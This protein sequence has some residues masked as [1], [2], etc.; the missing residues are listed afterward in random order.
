MSQLKISRAELGQFL[1]EYQGLGSKNRFKGK[2]GIL[3]YF[4]RVGC[5]QYDPLNVVGRN[6]DLT[7]QS[8]IDGYQKSMLH[9]LLY[10]ERVLVDGWDKQMSIYKSV[11]WNKMEH[12]RTS[13]TESSIR[14]LKHRK[15]IEALDYTEHVKDKLKELGATKPGA[16]DIGAVVRGTWG[17]GK[18]SSVV[19]DF[20]F[21][22]GELGIYDKAGTQKVYDFIENLLSD[23]VLNRKS[24]FNNDEDFYDWYV[25]RR[26]GSQG[27]YWDK[28]GDGWLGQYISK[29][30]IRKSAVERLAKKGE[31]LP[32]EV[33][34]F[35]E[36]FYIRKEDVDLLSDFLNQVKSKSTHKKVR[37]LAPLDNFMWDRKLIEQVFG[38]NYRW[39]VYKPQA[40]REYGYYVL[41][42]LY[43]DKFVARFEPEHVK[44]GKT[45][46]IK[47]W[48]WEEGVKPSKTMT[49]AIKKA[50]K[51]FT[52]YLEVESITNN[53]D[54]LL[55]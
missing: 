10:S 40:Q 4:D 9:D 45:L 44:G 28:S 46:T 30:G 52:T 3:S 16:I 24:G 53:I 51:D 1:I 41:P 25:K 31:I 47:N 54:D 15:S 26:I 14:T 37:F 49:N 17:H 48:W 55:K 34:S 21:H 35:K 38:F 23:E 19:M 43:G 42:V 12:V 13:M 6:A 39:E 8:R 11:D 36:V 2:E 29:A 33:E 20:L 5:V 22:T 18:I 32:V 50:F 7:L 27:I